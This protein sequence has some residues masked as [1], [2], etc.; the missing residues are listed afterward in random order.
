M[1]ICNKHP[2]CLTPVSLG[3]ILR[4]TE[5]EYC[6]RGGMKEGGKDVD[7]VNNNRSEREE[8]KVKQLDVYP[9]ETSQEGKGLILNA[10]GRKSDPGS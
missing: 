7:R 4:D 10:L 2:A 3:P 6:L 9:Y 8:K 1:C 5:L